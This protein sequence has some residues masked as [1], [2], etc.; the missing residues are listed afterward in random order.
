MRAC[1][2][3]CVQGRVSLAGAMLADVSS[4]HLRGGGWGPSWDSVGLALPGAGN[5]RLSLALRLAVAPIN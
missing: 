1:V 2:R 4:T 5:G 3:A